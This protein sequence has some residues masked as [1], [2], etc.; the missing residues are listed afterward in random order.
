M[1]QAAMPMGQADNLH[2]GRNIKV[3]NLA[4]CITWLSHDYQS[5]IKDSITFISIHCLP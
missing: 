3:T 1:D 4:K 2:D 5:K